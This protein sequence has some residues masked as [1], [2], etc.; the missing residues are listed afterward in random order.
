MS[1]PLKGIRVIDLSRYI[2]GPYC[3]MLLGDLGAEVIKVEKPAVGEDSRS[4]GPFVNDVSLYFTQ[5]NKNKKSMTLDL[6]KEQG[7]NI[8]QDLIRGCAC[9]KF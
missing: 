4:M 2:A 7:I 1:G 8:L 6:R 3:C 9:R 5:Y